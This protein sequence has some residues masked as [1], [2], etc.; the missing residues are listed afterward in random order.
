MREINGKVILIGD[1]HFGVKRFSIPFL[2]N[3]IKFFTDE[4]FPYMEEN[5]I[6]Y[7]F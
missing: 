1:C 7:I 3:T 4:V 2:H 6:K 5:N